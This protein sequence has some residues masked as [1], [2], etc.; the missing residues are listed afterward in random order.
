MIKD[1]SNL[2]GKKMQRIMQNKHTE[3]KLYPQGVILVG[4]TGLTLTERVRALQ[5]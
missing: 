2:D 5:P 4:A 3:Y 1:L